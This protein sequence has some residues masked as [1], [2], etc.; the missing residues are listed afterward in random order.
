VDVSAAPPGD[1]IKL[2]KSTIELALGESVFHATAGEGGGGNLSQHSAMHAAVQL[3]L[4]TQP[5]I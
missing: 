3:Q 2:G 1:V 5:C 4:G